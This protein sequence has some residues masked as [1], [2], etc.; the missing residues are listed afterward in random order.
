MIL[1]RIFFVVTEDL[2]TVPQAARHCAMS[3]GTIWKYVKSGEIKAFM[4]PGGQYRI[5]QTDFN[6]FMKRNNMYPHASDEPDSQRILLVDDEPKI[7]KMLTTILS[8]AGYSLKTAKDGFDAGVKLM[9]FKPGLVILDLIMPGMDGFEVC[10][11]IKTNADTAHIKVLAVTGHDCQEN[12]DRILSEGA[13]AYLTK[14]FFR[15]EL[16]QTIDVLLKEKSQP[17]KTSA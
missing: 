14:P 11:Q 5:R 7:L 17:E 9:T 1:K 8:S 12:R 6:A 16:M 4:T 15:N 2:L 3:R 10:R 13:D